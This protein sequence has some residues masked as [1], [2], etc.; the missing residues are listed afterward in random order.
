MNTS[1]ISAA[2]F[3]RRALR[4]ALALGVC[5]FDL[6]STSS[7]CVSL[8]PPALDAQLSESVFEYPFADT[9]DMKL[10]HQRAQLLL[11]KLDTYPGN[12]SSDALKDR[13]NAIKAF[14]SLT[15]VD[16]ES[17]SI[18]DFT[19]SDNKTLRKLRQKI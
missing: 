8:P 19:R 6:S 2:S 14:T 1:L 10:I 7:P 11:N 5:L 17:Y 13:L 18:I 16:G 15:T 3:G 4:F 9:Q 12:A